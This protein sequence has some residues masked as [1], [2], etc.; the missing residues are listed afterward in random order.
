MRIVSDHHIHDPAKFLPALGTALV[1]GIPKFRSRGRMISED[2]K[3]LL[4]TWEALSTKELRGYIETAIPEAAHRFTL[5]PI[6]DSP[7]PPLITSIFPFSVIQPGGAVIIQGQNFGAQPG[8]FV[9]IFPGSPPL[10]LPMENLQWG[11]NFAA[12]T[13]PWLLGLKDQ[14]VLFQIVRQ[15]GAASNQVS[16]QLT[17]VRTVALLPGSIVTPVSC[18]SSGADQCYVGGFQDP[19]TVAGAHAALFSGGSGSDV[20]NVQLANGWVFDHYEWLAQDGVN[21]G[22]FGQAPDPDGLPAFTIVVNW[23]SGPLGT[24]ISELA[25]Y[26]VGPMGVGFQ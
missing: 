19:F 17:A 13:I 11:D 24:S 3:Q 25:I 6:L 10:T 14:E 5:I 7:G 12:G 4:Q 15:D 26:V 1:K 8:Q 21:G 9:I 18:G 20:Y 2:Q 23:G 16:A 22:P